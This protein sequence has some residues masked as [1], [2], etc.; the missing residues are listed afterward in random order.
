MMG[1]VVRDFSLC[2][3]REDVS[4]ELLTAPQGSR[5]DRDKEQRVTELLDQA[6]PELFTNISQ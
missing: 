4:S 1:K 6:T 5:T 2:L 3:A